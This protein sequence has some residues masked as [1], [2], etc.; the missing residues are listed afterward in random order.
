MP[1]KADLRKVYDKSFNVKLDQFDDK[2]YTSI[3]QNLNIYNVCIY[4]VNKYMYLISYT[5]YIRTYMY[6]QCTY[7]VAMY[8]I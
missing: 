7:N 3:W 4:N 5:L 6:V 8:I 2:R 1:L